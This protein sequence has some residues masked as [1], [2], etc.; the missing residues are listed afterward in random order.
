MRRLEHLLSADV[1]PDTFVRHLHEAQMAASRDERRRA[2]EEKDA[3]VGARRQ[4]EARFFELLSSCSRGSDAAVASAGT[5]DDV[6]AGRRH[7]APVKLLSLRD[8]TVL[9]IAVSPVLTAMRGDTFGTK[10]SRRKQRPNAVSA[11]TSSPAAPSF[12]RRCDQRAAA[13]RYQ[14]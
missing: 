3:R 10:S 9:Q 6:A 12:R 14:M 11:R 4:R 13:P 1:T 8:P 2:K 5:A 7:A